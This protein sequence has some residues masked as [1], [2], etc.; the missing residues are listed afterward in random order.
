MRKITW[1]LALMFIIAAQGEAF[2]LP[3]CGDRPTALSEPWIR[4]GLACLERVIDDDSAG[5]L[6][7]SALAAAGD[8]LYAAR[9]LSGE[10]VR[11]IDGDGDGLPEMPGTAARGLAL[12]YAL[13]WHEDVLYVRG[14]GAVYRLDAA[15]TL[16]TLVDDLPMGEFPVGGIALWD[17]R[18]YVGLG[19]VCDACPALTD[20][21]GIER[22]GVVSFAL[23]GSDR[24]VE[25][26]GLRSPNALV[27]HDGALYVSD[28]APDAHID[29][30]LLDEINRLTPGA[31]FGFPSCLGADSGAACADV[32]RP[33]VLLPTGSDPLAMASY[34]HDLL[35]SL[36]GRLL[37]VLYGSRGRVDLRGYQVVAADPQTG[38][39]VDVMPARPDDSPISAF[40]PVEMSYRGSG[41]YPHR[42]LGV[43][44]TSAG[45]VMLSVGG[46][47]I[48]A[49]RP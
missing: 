20:A 12:P 49:L 9:P 46:G 35:P 11:L 24:R 36:N 17:G 37:V 29:T 5:V 23:D 47:R 44:V 26:V 18:L 1:F 15:G 43:T 28:S 45:W 21:T 7:Y 19:A 40:T 8:S 6:G 2:S 27:V 16:T 4:I 10:I 33:V 32:T 48:M 22:G 34:S 30:P 25:A 41:F 31:D 3:P 38:L 13:T 42:P 14:R 39:V